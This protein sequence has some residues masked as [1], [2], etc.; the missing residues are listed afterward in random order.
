M[1]FNNIYNMD[2]LEGMRQMDDNSVD[3]I[4]TDP[5]YAVEFSKGF[6]DSFETVSKLLPE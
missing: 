1:E 2:C 6:D 3:L 4:I 5:P